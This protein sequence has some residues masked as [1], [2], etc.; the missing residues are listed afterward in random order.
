MTFDK[1]STTKASKA[2]LLAHSIKM[3]ATKS[4]MRKVKLSEG[5]SLIL[6]RNQCLFHAYEK[7]FS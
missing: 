4:A 7:S 3:N 1:R 6:L 5:E 2:R